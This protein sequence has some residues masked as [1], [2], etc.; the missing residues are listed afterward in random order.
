MIDEITL[1]G[2][3]KKF[4]IDSF[5]VLREYLQV[6]F[7]DKLYKESTLKNTYFKG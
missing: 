3:S 4:E 5:T 7:L 6:K 1:K 2:L